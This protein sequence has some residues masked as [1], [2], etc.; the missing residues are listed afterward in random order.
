MN[1]ERTAV[2]QLVAEF[3][4]LDRFRFRF[5]GSVYTAEPEESDDDDSEASTLA[6]SALA[7]LADTLYF[8][9]HCGL[10]AAAAARDRVGSA[11]VTGREYLAMLSNANTGSGPWQAGWK[12]SDVAADAI[13]AVRWNVA[14]RVAAG[15]WKS[16]SARPLPGDEVLVRVPKEYRQLL[17]GFYIALGDA[18]DDL[19]GAPTVRVY[20]NA[21]AREAVI[22]VREITTALNTSR[23][24]FQLKT[25]VNPRD[26]GRI[27]SVILYLR[28][29]RY[30]D[31]VPVLGNALR[32]STAH[33]GSR[34][35]PFTRWLAPGVGAAEDPADGTSCGVR[36]SSCRP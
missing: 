8:C 31:A 11:F 21:G 16:S 30:S 9:V 1:S 24:P 34:V 23:V 14:Y 20:L 7:L 13:T 5:R 17:P 36:R 10:P 22:L 32:E 2:E 15:D 19:E 26:F 12:V 3:E 4:P 25:S 29:D 28:R 33:L 35:S 27:D 6:P 18:D